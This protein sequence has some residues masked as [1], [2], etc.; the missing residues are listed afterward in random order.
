MPEVSSVNAARIINTS[1]VTI[2]RY[3]YGGLL[4]ARRQGLRKIM[5]IE[6]DELRKFAQEHQYRFDEKLAAELAK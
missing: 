2:R 3:V 4:P 1:D 6:V 5:H